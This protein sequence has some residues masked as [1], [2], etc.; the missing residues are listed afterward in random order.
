VKIPF[1]SW[2]PDQPA[3]GS[4]DSTDAKNVFP[5]LKGYRPIGSLN[6]YTGAL[7]GRCQGAWSIKDDNGSSV[8]FSGDAA[9]LYKLSGTTWT[10]TT[11]TVGGAYATP[12]DAQWRFIK[13]GSLGIAVNGSDVPQKFTLTS[14]TNWSALGGS[15]PTGRYITSVREFVVMGCLTGQKNRVYW[16]SSNNAEGWTVGT[17]ECSFQDMFDGGVV[18]A[19]I[20]GEVGY[21]FQERQIV[22]MVRTVPPTSFQFDVVE[23]GRGVLAPYSVV[24]IGPAVF[25]LGQDGFYLFDGQSSKPIGVDAVDKTFFADLNSSYLD[26]ISATIDPINKLVFVAYPSQSSPQGTPDKVIIY[27][28]ALERWSYAVF[29]CEVLTSIFSAGVTLEGLDAYSASIETL[30]PSMDA[31]AWQGGALRLAAF[32]TTHALAYFTGSN[33]SAVMTT[34]E[35]QVNDGGRA[36]ISEVT[37]LVDTSAATVALGSRETQNGAVSYTSESSQRPTGICPVRSSGRF[38]RA[39]ITVPSGSSWTYAM[40]VDVNK[41]TSDGAR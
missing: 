6:A 22:R 4:G 11:R 40:G 3:L 34:M 12:T 19:L 14:S 39:R 7:T 33:L 18:Q 21:I 26:R 17:N 35:S 2:L 20:G 41:A 9:K 15:P 38:H 23:Q 25:Y 37:P 13:F 31:A 24:S 16:S 29:N 10:D 1:G 27:N 30:T 36:F 28:W 5:A 8:S 32:D